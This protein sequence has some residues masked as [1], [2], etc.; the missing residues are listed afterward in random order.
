MTA[1][2]TFFMTFAKDSS[3][4]DDAILSII[5]HFLTLIIDFNFKKT[6][7]WTMSGL[8]VS[9]GCPICSNVFF[10]LLSNSG[11]GLSG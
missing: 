10:S 4:R 2:P 7:P 11:F 6:I 8:N 1:Q 3:F 9:F 5:S